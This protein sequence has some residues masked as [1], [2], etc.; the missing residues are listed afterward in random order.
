MK[1][2]DFGIQLV[3]SN[4]DEMSHRSGI[5]EMFGVGTVDEEDSGGSE[6]TRSERYYRLIDA[7]VLVPL[8]IMWDD[9][10]ARLG[11]AI[12]TFFV[13]MATVWAP[14]YPKVYRN[15]APALVRPFN[16]EYTQ[17]I[18]RFSV[19]GSTF[20]G[21][22]VWKYPLGTDGVGRPL[23]ARIVNAAPD[24]AQLVFAGA[25][26]S[27]AFAVIIGC[28]AGYFRGTVDDV[29]MG[30]TDIVLTIPGLPLIIL[31][32]AIIEP[33]NMFILGMLLAIDN[34]PGQHARCA[35]RS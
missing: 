22:E 17:S 5:E 13:F 21:I 11:F 20:N 31:L 16:P 4:P 12:L 19:G 8:R 3:E 30:L 6:L 15:D 28:A 35:R 9:W 33:D 1:L 18:L 24:M 7:Y 25:V 14:M 32:T 27:I 23:L 29:L 10:R 34:W 2:T 26:V